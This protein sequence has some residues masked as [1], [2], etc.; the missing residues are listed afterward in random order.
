MVRV[1]LCVASVAVRVQPHKSEP[2]PAIPVYIN[3]ARVTWNIFPGSSKLFLVG[4]EAGNVEQRRL[5]LLKL[6]IGDGCLHRFAKPLRSIS[7]DG[8]HRIP[9]EPAFYL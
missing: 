2:P 1:A 8:N 5:L 9:G 3:L 4:G 7:D 6:I